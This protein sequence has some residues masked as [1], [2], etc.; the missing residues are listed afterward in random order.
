LLVSKPVK[1]IAK[2]GVN[3]LLTYTITNTSKTTAAFG[4]RA[5]LLHKNGVQ[6]LPAIYSDG[7]FSLMQGE[8]KILQIEV[9]PKILGGGYSLEATPYN[10]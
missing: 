4:I 5:Q 2:N 3:Q 10:N 9:D 6:I 7:Y 8:S 1:S